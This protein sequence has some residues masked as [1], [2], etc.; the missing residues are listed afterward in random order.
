M[1]DPATFLS[2]LLKE[3]VSQP[4]LSVA[5]FLELKKTI[6][7]VNSESWPSAVNELL[8]A[9]DSYDNELVL[10]NLL[11]VSQHELKESTI[12]TLYLSYMARQ[13]V[14][15]Q[16]GRLGA[17]LKA[18]MKFA[19]EVF[20]FAELWIEHIRGCDKYELLNVLL[21]LLRWL[22]CSDFVE[23]DLRAKLIAERTSIPF[24][25]IC[26]DFACFQPACS[27]ML[28]LILPFACEALDDAKTT[29][30]ISFTVLSVLMKTP[31]EG[32]IEESG[33]RDRFNFLLSS[34]ETYLRCPP[35]YL[36]YI[37][38]P[39]DSIHDRCSSLIS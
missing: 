17:D 2:A 20:K 36:H 33:I 9:G 14:F 19:L 3:A 11:Q 25:L 32:E 22:V 16:V 4:K 29:P 7:R 5:V 10:L 8:A 13:Y 34:F 1:R 21:R 23:G 35:H 26:K 6:D 24:S 18:G 37:A 12:N 30:S 15:N 27:A 39:S 28:R 31:E 38:L